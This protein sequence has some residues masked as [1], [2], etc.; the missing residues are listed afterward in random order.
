MP[1][2]RLTKPTLLGTVAVPDHVGVDA[3]L[4][5][6]EKFAHALRDLGCRSLGLLGGCD[7]VLVLDASWESRVVFC[8]VSVKVTNKSKCART[9]QDPLVSGRAP[10]VPAHFEARRLEVE[11]R[12]GTVEGA[13]GIRK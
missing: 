2:S 13:G 8:K 3:G 4:P 9:W 5:R 6:Q 10:L 11:N 12:R 1:V 7:G